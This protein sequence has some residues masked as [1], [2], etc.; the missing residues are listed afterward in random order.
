MFSGCLLRDA[1]GIDHPRALKLLPKHSQLAQRAP[2]ISRG[3]STELPK[4]QTRSSSLLRPSLFL[5]LSPSNPLFASSLSPLLPSSLLSSPLLASF[6][7]FSLRFVPQ[8][9]PED[10]ARRTARERLNKNQ[11]NG[12]CKSTRAVSYRDQTK[13]DPPKY[14]GKKTGKGK[15]K[16]T[17]RSKMCAGQSVGKQK[18]PERGAGGTGQRP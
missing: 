12:S 5:S 2:E 17:C 1:L 16:K 11:G 6:P 18:G 10:T 3:A 8:A 14:K 4:A 9:L 7:P 15:K 13:A